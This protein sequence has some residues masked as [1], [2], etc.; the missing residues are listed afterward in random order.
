MFWRKLHYIQDQACFYHVCS[1]AW[2]S[3]DS[4]LWSSQ[5][6]TFPQSAREMRGTWTPSVHSKR[7]RERERNTKSI[8][9]EHESIQYW[10]WK[11]CR[12][13]ENMQNI[14]YKKW[15][16]QI[17][18]KGK[19]LSVTLMGILQRKAWSE[20]AW[21]L[22]KKSGDIRKQANADRDEFTARRV[23]CKT[24]ACDIHEPRHTK[25]WTNKYRYPKKNQYVTFN[26]L[27]PFI[28][29]H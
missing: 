24:W 13:H 15:I 26:T 5:S 17:W 20:G 25:I 21:Y 8:K 14:T 23:N 7:E 18:E 10:Y 28:Q 4:S 11:F 1:A 9:R 19:T 29:Q 16:C 22:W 12:K 3:D 6:C 2:F 27:S